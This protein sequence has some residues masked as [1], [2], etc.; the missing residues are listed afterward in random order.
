MFKIKNI[1]LLIVFK[2]YHRCVLILVLGSYGAFTVYLQL[3]LVFL[4]VLIYN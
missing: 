4:G 1:L 3:R 2:G